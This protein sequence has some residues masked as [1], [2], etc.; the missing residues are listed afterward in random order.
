MGD[1]APHLETVT[2][3]AGV[4][5]AVGGVVGDKPVAVGA[6]F[7]PLD[8]ELAV[9]SGYHDVARLGDK[10]AVDGHQGPVG[11][12]RGCPVHARALDAGEVGAIG[13][14][15]QH[16][17]QV[18]SG[19]WGAISQAGEAGRDGSF[20]LHEPQRLADN[21][22]NFDGRHG[23]AAKDICTGQRQ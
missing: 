10:G 20:A 19:T 15:H 4:D 2:K 14:G 11:D 22:Q 21:L 8:G 23:S 3:R 5:G 12:M 9:D 7:E 17:I 6:L 13:V 16:V 1:D 18:D